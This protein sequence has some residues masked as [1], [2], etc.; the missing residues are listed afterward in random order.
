[1]DIKERI[2]TESGILFSKYGIR[3]MTMDAISSEM[4]ISKRTIY[5]HFRD[6][7]TLLQEVI[8]YHN[9]LQ[10]EEANHIIEQSN[11]AIEAMFLILRQ[12]IRIM[13]QINPVFF[14]DLTTYYASTFNRF[15]EHSKNRNYD[16]TLNLLQTGVRQKVFRNEL[17]IDIVNRTFHELFKL[18]SPDHPLTQKD[19]NRRELF[20]NII[21]PYFRGIATEKGAELIE[22]CKKILEY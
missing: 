20:D 17:N 6:K 19:Y 21:I 16:F 5:E 14:Y 13:K 7:E 15:S 22:K 2:I 18:F 12:S 4:R 11:N 10:A 8:L 9:N 3:S 1:M